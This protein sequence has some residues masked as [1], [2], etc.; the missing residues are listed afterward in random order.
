M[1][2]FTYQIYR[3]VFPVVKRELAYWRQRAEKIPDRELRQQAL[4]SIDN[5][6]F[7]CEG[8]SIYS[9]PALK[10]RDILIP[11][12][13][14][15][16]T[17]SDYLDN[18]CDRST[19]LDP[20]DFRQL[21]QS[22]LD[23]VTPDAPLKDYYRF[24]DEKEDGNYLNEL[25]LTCQR[26]ILQLPGYHHVQDEV[27]R[28]ASLYTDMQVHKH[29]NPDEREDR[30]KKWWESYASQYPGIY[31]NEFA[32]AAGSTLGVFMLFQ[33][34]VRPKVPSDEIER[35]L[36]AYFPWI[37]GLHILLDYL[38]DLEEDRVGGDLNFIT[39]YNGDTDV[40]QRLS[41]IAEEARRT[42]RLLPDAD[43]HLMIIDGLLG[44]YLADGKVNRQPGVASVSRYLLKQASWKARFF[45]LNSRMYRG[46][47]QEIQR[48]R[49]T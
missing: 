33:T 12:I 34:A 45:F 35:I 15:Y 4:A 19:S 40:K 21:H 29:V 28:L 42:A 47:K 1:F 13:V 16:Q 14:A 44:L 39:Y 49:H 30:L 32:A 9:I 23:A 17:I 20:Q 38:V 37:T 18:L 5:K 24:R 31:W 25:V 7:H 11:L 43:F 2:R 10:Q 3:K 26:M 22:M 41:F 6:T 48:P 27:V 46:K 36:D 8:G